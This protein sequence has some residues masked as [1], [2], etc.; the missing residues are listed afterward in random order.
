MD[1]KEQ[2]IEIKQLKEKDL[3]IPF[4][5]GD[6]VWY[7]FNTHIK[8]KWWQHYSAKITGVSGFSAKGKQHIFFRTDDV[9]SIALEDTFRYKRDAQKEQYKRNK[10]IRQ[11]LKE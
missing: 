1:T 6:I 3:D 2:K 9:Y 4:K 7:L 5:K 11:Q 10:R 8:N